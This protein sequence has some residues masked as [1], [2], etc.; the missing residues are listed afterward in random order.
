MRRAGSVLSEGWPDHLTSLNLNCLTC[1]IVIIMTSALQGCW[2][3]QIH[4]IPLVLQ[5]MLTKH[6]LYFR[7]CT[8]TW[9]YRSENNKDPS[10]QGAYILYIKCT[11][12]QMVKRA[13]EEPYVM[14]WA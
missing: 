9:E 13:V 14:R 11:G 1:K 12:S 8:R 7:H 6:L 5:H 2:E 4:K 10:P 3:D